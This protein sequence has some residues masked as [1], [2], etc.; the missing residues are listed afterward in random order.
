[1]PFSSKT[2]ARRRENG[3]R[4]P[5]V[6]VP[7]Y[8]EHENVEDL[9]REI[10]SLDVELDLLFIDDNSTDGTRQILDRLALEN[11]NVRVI[12]R[13]GKMGIGSAHK[14]GISYAYEQGYMELVTMDCDFTHSPQCIPQLLSKSRQGHDVVV[15][16]RYLQIDSL[17]DWNL[18][19]STLSRT[20]HVLTRL[21]LGMPFDATGGF[22]CY[23]LA[24]V[25]RQ[26]F[27]LVGSNGYSFFFESL[28]ILHRNEMTIAEIPVALPNRTYGHSKMDFSEVQNSVRLLC[29]T[30]FKTL[31][32]PEKFEVS[33]SIA[34]E[35]VNKNERDDQ[36]WE[37]YWEN[38]KTKAGGLAY[39]AVAAFYRKYIIRRALNAFVDK[40]FV[41]GSCILHAGCG[42]G[43]VDTDIRSRVRITA[44]DISVNALNFYKRTNKQSCTL[45]HGS[46]YS[47]PLADESMD[48]IYNLGVMEHFTEPEI[49]RILAEFHRV[50][51]P[52]GRMIIFWPPEFGLSVMFFKV[53]T[54]IYRDIL[55]KKDVKFHPD[56]LTRIR[57]RS[58]VSELFQAQDFAVVRYYFGPLDLFTY[59]VVVVEKRTAS[60]IMAQRS[61]AVA[62]LYSA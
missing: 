40:Y 11:T 50:L 43:Q 61:A 52:H 13:S 58:H 35:L 2:Q 37:A 21:F 46:I 30:Y 10:L 22:R 54:V 47:I 41:P 34:D 8:N 19:R 18:Y 31:F 14:A 25:P 16:S 55:G 29:T 59:A 38:E 57:S 62:P 42:G 3:V 28:Y 56:E 51:K 5:L 39:D 36:G 15:A 33:A 53:L 49:Q 48:G 1:M 24:T 4:P 32:N 26:A 20:G 45:L 27:E 17:E 60:P 44:L 9:C 7:T 6:F 12:H 23:R